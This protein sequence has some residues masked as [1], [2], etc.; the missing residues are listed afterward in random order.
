MYIS[1]GDLFSFITPG[2]PITKAL[3]GTSKLTKVLP[4]IKTLLPILHFP[5]I[6]AFG[7]IQQFFPI[8]GAQTLPSF[9]PPPM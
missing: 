5:T 7:P 4:A 3:S 9:S 1:T 6:V 2:L 8:S